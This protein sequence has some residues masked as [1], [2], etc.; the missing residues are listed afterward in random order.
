MSRTATLKPNSRL[1]T[2]TASPATRALDQTLA[3]IILGT[4]AYVSPGQARAEPFDQ[5]ADVRAFADTLAA[6]L[7]KEP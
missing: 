7:I 1:P 5:Q 4:A 2:L 6:V 3:G